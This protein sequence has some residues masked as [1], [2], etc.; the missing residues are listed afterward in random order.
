MIQSR[1]PGSSAFDRLATMIS[2]PAPGAAPIARPS[3]IAMAAACAALALAGCAQEQLSPGLEITILPATIEYAC[4]EGRVLRVERAGGA[5]SATATIATRR[6]VLPRVDSAAQEKYAE[7]ATALYLDGDIAM[8]ESDGR[9]LAA[10][11]RST[12]ALPRAP[13]LRPYVF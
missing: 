2:R 1:A 9:V 5:T 10:N 13:S 11:C 8:L 12:V 6:W 7:G 4:D 3:R